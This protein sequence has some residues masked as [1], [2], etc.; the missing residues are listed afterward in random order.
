MIAAIYARRERLKIYTYLSKIEHVWYMYVWAFTA[1]ARVWNSLP[2]H[3]TSASSLS[4]FCSRLKCHFFRRCLPWIYL[5][6][7]CR[8]WD[9]T[10]LLFSDTL[11]V[12]L[13][14]R[15]LKLLFT[16]G[17]TTSYFRNYSSFSE[18]R[19]LIHVACL[20]CQPAARSELL[21]ITLRTLGFC[22]RDVPN[23]SCLTC[24]NNASINRP[25]DD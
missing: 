15:L 23:S 22:W 24:T 9:V 20:S 12:P 14:L 25:A 3:V 7:S 10:L 11:I 16:V 17:A 8:V 5:S 21:N 13:T 19:T 1:A 6:L 4:V 2:Q 18:H